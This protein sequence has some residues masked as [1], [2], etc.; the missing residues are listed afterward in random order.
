MS[1]H[2]ADADQ[3]KATRTT[4]PYETVAA[5]AAATAA[6]TGRPRIGFWIAGALVV[7][8]LAVGMGTYVNSRNALPAA[9]VRVAHDPARAL[10]LEAEAA[11]AE[12]GAAAANRAADQSAAKAQALTATAARDR[13]AAKQ[14]SGGDGNV[15]L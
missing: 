9:P 8:A 12:K 14:A 1:T 13:V 7:V 2:Y 15:V 5:P 11:A 10:A 3:V 4:T 6:T